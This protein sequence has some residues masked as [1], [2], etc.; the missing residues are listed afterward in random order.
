LAVLMF[1]QGGTAYHLACDMTAAGLRVAAGRSQEREVAAKKQ[2]R[3]LTFSETCHLVPFI[4][5]CYSDHCS[6]SKM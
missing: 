4:E 3:R 1:R 5:A 2:K 6:R